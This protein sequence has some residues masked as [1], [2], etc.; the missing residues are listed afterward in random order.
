MLRVSQ[1]N[2]ARHNIF[3]R[4]ESCS[5]S[6]QLLLFLYIYTHAPSPRLPAPNPLQL[7][8]L[9]RTPLYGASRTWLYPSAPPPFV[10]L[11]DGTLANYALDVPMSVAD[12]AEAGRRDRGCKQRIPGRGWVGEEEGSNRFAVTTRIARAI[13]REITTVAAM[14]RE[15]KN[16][17]R[18]LR[19]KVVCVRGSLRKCVPGNMSAGACQGAI[20]YAHCKRLVQC[21]LL[22]PGRPADE[23]L[24]VPR[25]NSWEHV[26]LRERP[27]LAC[28]MC[29]YICLYATCVNVDVV[30][31]RA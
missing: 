2:Q 26:A 8:R 16:R 13:W 7:F 22:I 5:P 6:V 20:A 23:R 4:I 31:A 15:E 3:S 29:R 9:R 24:C 27:R 19:L 28:L 30:N 25:R 11:G 21:T 10:P 18:A 14:G 1:L 12:C 17:R